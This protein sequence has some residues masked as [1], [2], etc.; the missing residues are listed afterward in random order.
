MPP[1]ASLFAHYD[2]SAE[3]LGE[4]VV[5][6]LP[7]GAEQIVAVTFDATQGLLTFAP[8]VPLIAGGTYTIRW[9]ALRGLGAAAVGRGANVV[10]TVGTDLDTEAPR[11]DGL[12]GLQW[13]LERP[14]NDC[15]KAQEERIV[16]DLALGPASDDGGRAGL[17]LLVFQ[18]AGPR[19]GIGSVPVLAR[20]MPPANE[21]VRVALPPADTVGRTC[22]AAL[23][24]D[25]T[26]KISDGGENELCVDVTAPPFFHGCAVATSGHGAPRCADLAFTGLALALLVAYVRRSRRVSSGAS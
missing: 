16:F 3:Y 10:F 1:N 8:S 23:V 17:T 11:F 20:A 21:H 18:T 2:I 26:G 15:A 12:T 13:D 19:A 22:L 9:P 6:V 5:L 14:Y 25:L 4:D 7:G 24:R